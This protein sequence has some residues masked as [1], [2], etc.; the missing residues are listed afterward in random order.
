MR[1]DLSLCDVTMTGHLTVMSDS[2]DFNV[3]MYVAHSRECI[4]EKHD[5]SI[6]KSLALPISDII[7]DITR[8]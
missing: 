2:D 3:C 5:I 4:T 1:R 7:S 8:S 6:C